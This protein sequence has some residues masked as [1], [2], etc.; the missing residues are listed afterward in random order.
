MPYLRAGYDLDGPIRARDRARVRSLLLH[1]V[2]R[3]RQLPYHP[4]TVF[5]R[6]DSGLF[7]DWPPYR[8][9]LFGE[10]PCVPQA[11]PRALP[12]ANRHAPIDG[13]STRESFLPHENG[14]FP[15]SVLLNGVFLATLNLISGK[16]TNISGL[17][18]AFTGCP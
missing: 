1:S 13:H 4:G 17:K 11:G 8:A 9:G 5:S 6:P 7:I 15:P 2:H 16:F 18:L 3:P 14:P 10:P 12:P